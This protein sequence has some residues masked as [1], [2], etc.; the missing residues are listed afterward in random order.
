LLHHIIFYTLHFP[1]HA[2]VLLLV[3]EVRPPTHDFFRSLNLAGANHVPVLVLDLNRRPGQE[4]AVAV[5]LDL[6]PLAHPEPGNPVPDGLNF[7]VREKVLGPTRSRGVAVS[8]ETL[9]WPGRTARMWTFIAAAA[10]EA[11]PVGRT[12]LWRRRVSWYSSSG[13]LATMRSFRISLRLPPLDGRTT[14]RSVNARILPRHLVRRRGV[15][16]FLVVV[17][18]I[19]VEVQPALPGSYCRITS[20]LASQKT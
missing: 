15:S 17:R 4:S 18:R 12:P 6:L 5:H 20:R 2:I 19:I 8:G 7:F 9:R 13:F 16:V 1:F 14:R 11:Q 3:L 10:R